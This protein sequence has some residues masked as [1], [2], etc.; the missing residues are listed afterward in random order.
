MNNETGRGSTTAIGI[1]SSDFREGG[2]DA[3]QEWPHLKDDTLLKKFNLSLW[4]FEKA[5][6]SVNDS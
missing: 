1:S 2:G 5:S 6:V 4:F 3:E